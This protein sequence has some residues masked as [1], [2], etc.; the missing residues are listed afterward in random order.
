M[1]ILHNESF[2][3]LL[4]SETFWVAVAF[5]IFVALIFKKAKKILIESLDKRIEEI[6]KRINEAK[7]LKTE[8]EN[9][10]N[11]A[12][13]NLKKM[14]DDKKRIINEANE[15]A[16][17]LENKLLNEEKIYSER[18]KKRISDRI[19]QSKN[20]TINDIKKLALDISIKSIKDLLNNEKEIKDDQLISKSITNLFY[21]SKKEQ[22]NYKDLWDPSQNG[23]FLVCLHPHK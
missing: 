15:E 16:K 8:A 17:N 22:K 20:Q 18:F 3:K 23:D 4:H 9:N 6:K 21:K 19:E 14:V 13:R 5:F 12:K 1:E 10:L 11:E 7:E 2:L